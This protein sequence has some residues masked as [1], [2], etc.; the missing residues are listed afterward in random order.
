MNSGKIG[1]NGNTSLSFSHASDY[2]IVVD[3][4]DVPD[5]GKQDKG[6]D[7]SCCTMLWT[8]KCHIWQLCLNLQT[9]NDIMGL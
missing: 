9:K 2:V 1:A 3:K 8:I 7:N 5:D 4:A 6:D